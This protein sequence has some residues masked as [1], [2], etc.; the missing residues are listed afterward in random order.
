MERFFPSVPEP[1]ETKPIKASKKRPDCKKASTSKANKKRPGR[2]ND[3]AS[4]C[5]LDKFK[6]R[7]R[8]PMSKRAIQ[9][10]ERQAIAL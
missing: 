6:S 4:R 5:K 9:N 8:Q 7:V 3:K 10:I 1:D 2:K